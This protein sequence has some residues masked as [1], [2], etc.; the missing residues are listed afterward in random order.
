MLNKLPEKLGKEEKEKKEIV[1]LAKQ[2][3]YK[4]CRY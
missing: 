1:I 2:E 4:H 3:S